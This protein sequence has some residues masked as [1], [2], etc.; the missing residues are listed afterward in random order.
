M[1]ESGIFLRIPQASGLEDLLGAVHTP[2]RYVGKCIIGPDLGRGRGTL[3]RGI[4]NPIVT[5][6]GGR[7]MCGPEV[8]IL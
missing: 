4:S 2:V 6:R 5:G 1:A 7:G 8:T 3:R